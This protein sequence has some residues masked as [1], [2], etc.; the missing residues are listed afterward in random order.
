MITKQCR[1][2]LHLKENLPILACDAFPKGIPTIILKGEF[3]HTNEFEGDNGIRF[4]RDF[5]NQQQNNNYSDKIKENSVYLDNVTSFIKLNYKCPKGTVDD[6]NKCD[7]EKPIV[8]IPIPNKFKDIDNVKS[9]KIR[10]ESS[11]FLNQLVQNNEYLV[12]SLKSYTNIG[13]LEVNK[14]LGNR[15]SG[16]IPKEIEKIIIGLDSIFNLQKEQ[17][18][19]TSSSITTYRGVSDIEI[20]NLLGLN[21]KHIYDI[22]P[23]KIITDPKFVST[24]LNKEQALQFGRDRYGGSIITILI[25]KN[26]EALH[27]ES[28][29]GSED[30][31][32][33]NRNQ[34]Y[35]FLGVNKNIDNSG[36]D[37]NKPVHEFIFELVNANQKQN[38]SYL[39]NV[40]ET[41]KLNYKCPKGTVDDS[42]KCNPEEQEKSS[43]S[44]SKSASETFIGFKADHDFSSPQDVETNKRIQASLDKAAEPLKKF[45]KND[46][47]VLTMYSGGRFHQINEYLNGSMKDM[48]NS[49]D[50][51]DKANV[52]ESKQLI[53]KLDKLFTNSDLS[54][55]LVTYRGISN[56]T[57]SKYP[58]LVNALD[59]PGSEIEFPCFSSTSVLPFMA[60]N[61]TKDENGETGRLL[62]LQLPSGTKALFIGKDSLMPKELEVLI[63]RGTKFEVGK[64]KYTDIVPPNSGIYR[65][66]PAKHVKITT[67]RAIV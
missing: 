40:F 64:T 63:N 65:D 27:T 1:V 34:S 7:I 37:S 9:D 46:R 13:H 60:N 59:T 53:E 3:D 51:F 14:Y 54:E 15:I 25:P 47:H 30:E 39:A 57:L 2:C 31:L 18:F 44:D 55:P 36:L 20:E 5:G 19:L 48:E 26:S 42:N 38:S 6:S 28:V 35:K 23:G 45:S 56:K 12:N 62:E 21:Q 29:S 8:N 58:E 43:T 33:I 32:L 17:N 66:T 10:G 41:I 49:N 67:I 52:K 22:E 24:T 11:E 16:N 50:V 61:Y 4:E